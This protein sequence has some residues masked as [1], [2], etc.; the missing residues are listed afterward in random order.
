V[1]RLTPNGRTVAIIEFAK[2]GTDLA[3]D[4]NAQEG[5]LY[6]AL[7]QRMTAA[8]AAIRAEG[9]DPVVRAFVW[10]Q[11]ER[12]ATTLE[13]AKSYSANLVSFIQQIRASL[14]NSSLPFVIGRIQAPDKPFR[15]EVRQAQELAARYLDKVALVNTD[16]L[17]LLDAIH[18]D[19]PS[20][21]ELG[22]RFAAAI[23]GLL[24]PPGP[25][26]AAWAELP[27]LPDDEGFAGMYAGAVGGRLVAAGGTQF[28]GGVPWWRGGKKQWSDRIMILEP[29]ATAWRTAE[30][31]LP[32]KLGDGV[33]F[34]YRGELICIGGGD[35]ER[36]YPDV[37]S[38]K[39]ERDTVRIAPLMPLPLPCIKMGGALL[40]DV[41][42]II[43]GRTDPNST[44][45][46]KT[47]WAID[48]S[49]APAE[50]RWQVLQ[51]W[52]GPP[53]MMPIVATVQGAIYMIG[54]IEIADDQGRPKLLAPYLNDV[55]RFTP[56]PS[57]VDGTWEK[58]ASVPHAIAGAPS[59]AW[60]DGQDAIVVLGGIDGSLEAIADRSSIRSLP[61]EMLTYSVSRNAWTRSG[62][63]PAAQVR[64]NAPAFHWKGGYVIVG[65]ENL[66]ARRTHQV[67][68][69]AGQPGVVCSHRSF[70]PVADAPGLPRVL[71]LGDSISMGYTLAV[72]QKLAGHAN[73]HRPTENGRST[74]QTLE[75]LET[76][77]GMGKWDVIHFNCGIHD[78]TFV[79]HDAKGMEEQNGGHLQVP[80]ESYRSNLRAI[81]S[82]LKRTGATLIWATTTPVAPTATF[83]R[84]RDVRVYNAAALDIMA[85]NGIRVNDLFAKVTRDLENGN[86][87]WSDGVHYD[88]ASFNVLAGEVAGAI[89][90][91]LAPR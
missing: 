7:M 13:D 15:K 24:R 6:R 73:V 82:R 54:G 34:G 67:T 80:L 77:L 36:A 9:N 46:L 69:L 17:G 63:M 8:L 22:E 58:Q 76:Y 37:F 48:L 29:N 78:L 66:P 59:P 5:P 62:E 75:R 38:L 4:W 87:R 83:R 33:A 10:M 26:P 14:S 19:A 27:R 53:R 35:A 18:F 91:A 56:G 1:S 86:V 84:S 47:F 89:T 51:P 52:P 11:G 55:Y 90:E 71:L 81:V 21:I 44:A 30:N 64:V 57:G 31:P 85:E 40:G 2:G 25:P 50:R 45:A 32:R 61:G 72:R 68:M 70:A 88:D 74:R 39:P 28:V 41:L 20:L 49:Q 43:G 60:S 65:G 16:D 79:G 23:E 42:Y 12:D 3:R